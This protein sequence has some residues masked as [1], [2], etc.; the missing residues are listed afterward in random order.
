MAENKSGSALKSSGFNGINFGRIYVDGVDVTA[1]DDVLELA[2]D[3]VRAN[4]DRDYLFYR[5]ESSQ[6]RTMYYL[7]LCDDLSFDSGVFSGQSVTSYLFDVRASSTFTWSSPSD[8]SF[9][10]DNRSGTLSGK[11]AYVRSLVYIFPSISQSSS[12]SFNASDDEFFYSSIT[13][14]PLVSTSQEVNLLAC[15]AFILAVL[16]VSLW[17]AAIFRNVQR[18]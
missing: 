9:T 14:F 2:R 6:T 3:I 8:M 15:I 18:R 4:P 12:F 11:D 16:G 13:D 10:Y 1:A 7:I 17:F 5:S